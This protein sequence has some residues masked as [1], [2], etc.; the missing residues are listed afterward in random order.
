MQ[1]RRTSHCLAGK[2]PRPEKYR[3]STSFKICYLD[4]ISITA[5]SGTLAPGAPIVMIQRKIYINEYTPSWVGCK[6]T[7]RERKGWG[8]LKNQSLNMHISKR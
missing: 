3:H 4:I 1:R 8:G 7:E 6:R 5:K 2:N